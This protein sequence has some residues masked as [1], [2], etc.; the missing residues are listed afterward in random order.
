MKPEHKQKALTHIES[1]ENHTQV[2]K[3]MLEGKRPSDQQDA[4]RL[5]NQIER[6]L[7]LTKTLV[8]L[9]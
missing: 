4:L 8:E 9:A 1:V 5:T 3:E 7:E 6:L 2:I